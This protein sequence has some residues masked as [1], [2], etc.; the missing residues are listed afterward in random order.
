MLKKYY[1]NSEDIKNMKFLIKSS[2]LHQGLDIKSSHISEAF[3]YSIGYKTNSA[4]NT[5]LNLTKECFFAINDT[6]YEKKF[7]E[8]IFQLSGINV[9]DTFI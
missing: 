1:F 7:F 9:L 4:L 5:Y 3:A 8:R 2:L 6:E